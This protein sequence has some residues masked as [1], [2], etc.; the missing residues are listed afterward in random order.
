MIEKYLYGKGR[1]RRGSEKEVEWSEESKR[2]KNE[3]TFKKK[4]LVKKKY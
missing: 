3:L 1:R 4:I 2:R